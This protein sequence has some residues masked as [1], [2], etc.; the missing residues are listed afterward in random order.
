MTAK[1]QRLSITRQCQV[2][3]ISRSSWYYGSIQ[4]SE[5]DLVLMRLIDDI[6]LQYPFLGSRRIRDELGYRG[7][8]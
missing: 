3:G 7:L 4:V 8:R 1:D 2:V 6:H 5:A